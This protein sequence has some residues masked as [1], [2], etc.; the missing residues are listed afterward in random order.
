MLHLMAFVLLAPGQAA[1]AQISGFERQVIDYRRAIRQAELVMSSRTFKNSK[2]IDR[3]PK[4][5]FWLDGDRLRCDR[6]LKLEGEDEPTRRIYCRNCQIDKHFVFYSGQKLPKGKV[7][8]LDIHEMTRATAPQERIPEFRALGMAAEQIGDSESFEAVLAY[9]NRENLALTPETLN[10]V[11][12]Q[13]LSYRVPGG[14][15]VRAWIAKDRGPSV[16]RIEIESEFRGKRLSF[17]A[18]SEL[19]KMSGV[20]FPKK[21]TY[22]HRVDGVEVDRRVIDVQVKSFNKPIDPEV[23]TVAGIGIPPQTPI[24]GITDVRRGQLIWD[25]KEIVSRNKQPLPPEVKESNKAHRK[26]SWLIGVSAGSAV[27]AAFCVGLYFRRRPAEGGT[28]PA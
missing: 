9:P 17:L 1:P 15:S 12:C 20:W 14:G 27:L 2:E 22:I 11:D 6:W 3:E 5:Y 18:D 10:G 28:K 16:M 23:F 24:M 13:R 26:R 4:T 25:G 21:Y 19:E 7:M 8:V